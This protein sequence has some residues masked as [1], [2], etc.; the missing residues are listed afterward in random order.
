MKK[1]KSEIKK[2][3]VIGGV[4]GM[5]VGLPIGNL[6]A[7]NDETVE[8]VTYSV[9]SYQ[10]ELH[11]PTDNPTLDEYITQV[12]QYNSDISELDIQGAYNRLPLS[13]KY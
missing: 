3:L 8:T 12:R 1:L 2:A 5:V 4:V 10:Y 7:Q 13:V 6:V 11:V 9:D